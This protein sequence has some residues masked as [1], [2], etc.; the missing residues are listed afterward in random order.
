MSHCLRQPTERTRETGAKAICE[1][2]PA[3]TECPFIDDA[4]EGPLDPVLSSSGARPEAGITTRV[5]P[6][7]N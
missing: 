3:A 4:A 1:A 5:R 6:E 2:R 7:E